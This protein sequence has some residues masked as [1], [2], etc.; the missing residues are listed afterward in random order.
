MLITL[1]EVKYLLFT[2]HVLFLMDPVMDKF[3]PTLFYLDRGIDVPAVKK[4]NVS[5]CHTNDIGS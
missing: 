4:K 3:S 2:Q 1:Q 5:R